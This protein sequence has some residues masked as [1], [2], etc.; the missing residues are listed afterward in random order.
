M[1]TKI[2]M[3]ELQALVRKGLHQSSSFTDH[4]VDRLPIPSNI[5]KLNNQILDWHIFRNVLKTP[6]LAHIVSKNLDILRS[7]THPATRIIMIKNKVMSE[8]LLYIVWSDQWYLFPRQQ[9]KR[10]MASSMPATPRATAVGILIRKKHIFI[11][12]LQEAKGS[13]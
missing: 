9:A 8:A 6:H 12:F 3:R 10:T 13:R 11:G 7:I 5:T 4:K 2:G 1:F